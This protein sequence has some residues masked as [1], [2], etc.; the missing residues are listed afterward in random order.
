MNNR[1]ARI[2]VDISH[3]KL[4][5]AFS[6]KIPENLMD[7][8]TPGTQVMIPF[9]AGNKLIK[10]YV[11]ECTDTVDFDISKVKEIAYVVEKQVQAEGN[12]IR[13]AAWMKEQYGSTLIT[14]LKT[15]LPV[16][17]EIKGIVKKTVCSN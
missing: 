4:D 14:A 15:V 13:L 12:S 2:I 11:L 9:G 16:K 8:V 10:G 17:K 1:F 7:K 5:K 3:E 6:Y